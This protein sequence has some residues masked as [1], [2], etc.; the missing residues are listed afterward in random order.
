VVLLS[1]LGVFI[2]LDIAKN[3]RHLV[4]RTEDVYPHLEFEQDRGID[5]IDQLSRNFSV[6]VEKMEEQ[7]VLL[8][9]FEK[10]LQNTRKQLK[11]SQ[12][13]LKEMASR[14]ELTGLFNRRFLKSKLEDELSRA[15][16]YSHPLCVIFVD[17]DEFKDV[18]D[19]YGHPIGDIVLREFAE[20][21]QD[22][23]REVDIVARYGGEEFCI[24]LPETRNQE[25]KEA[26]MRARRKIEK[27]G[28]LRDTDHPQ[29]KI[30]A[31]LGVFLC[32]PEND[33]PEDIL[34]KAD[35]ALYKAKGE[36]RNRVVE[37]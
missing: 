11:A 7:R 34:R 8:S 29:L 27:H 37:Y 20:L 21:L 33:S 24:I 16:R 14:D 9:D 15:K 6:V 35:Q 19:K 3:V 26:A 25:A 1:L 4:K 30:T 28:F 10:D 23:F 18:N 2:T 31:S 17:I 12:A 32:D 13:K 36:G 22:S 5:E